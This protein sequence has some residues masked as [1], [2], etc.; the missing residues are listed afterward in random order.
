MLSVLVVDDEAT[1]RKNTARS[2]GRAGFEVITAADRT[3]ARQILDGSD[4]DV[5]CLYIHLPDED[6]FN[7]L[8]EVRQTFP[9]IPAVVMSGAANPEHRPRASQLGVKGFL[10]KRF[11]L[12]ELK[13]LVARCIETIEGVGPKGVQ[14]TKK[15]WTRR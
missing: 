14:K 2:L 3:G 11:R 8:E 13:V 10:S 7:L 1:L 12:A 5:L 6:G 9:R 4:V 15:R